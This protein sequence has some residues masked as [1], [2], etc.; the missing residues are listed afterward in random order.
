MSLIK[1]A[2]VQT[3]LEARAHATFDALMRAL[4]YPGRPQTLRLEER[5]PFKAI[6]EALLDLEV[7]AFSTEQLLGNDL[8]ATGAKLVSLERAEYVFIPHLTEAHLPLLQRVNRG[9]TLT[10]D[11]AA[12]LV[13][14][15]SFAEEPLESAQQLRLRGSGIKDSLEV[16]IGGLP[17][18]FWRVREAI[19]AF[20]IGWDVLL[21]SSNQILGLPR[22]TAV[23]MIAEVL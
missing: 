8:R 17:R 5:T 15:A 23:E 13:I 11:D 4:S 9:S 18:D 20:P 12:T 21:I 7:T 6:A 3:P 22:T 10:P 1:T 14:G 19:I 2:P 16:R